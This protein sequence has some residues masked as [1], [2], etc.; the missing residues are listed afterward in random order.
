MSGAGLVVER[1]SHRFGPRLV[2]DAVSL[3]VAP[4][5]V[6]CL[7]GPSG[8]G[9]STLLRIVAGLES[10]QEGAISIGGTLVAGPDV[11]VPPERRGV[12]LMFQDFALFP[13]L[14]VIQN[15]MFGLTD[16]AQA[17]R[18][19]RAKTALTR[20]AMDAFADMYPHTLS[21]GEQQRV[22]LARALAPRPRVMLLDEPFSGLDTGTRDRVRREAIKLL[23]ETGTPTLLVTHDPEEAMR[24]ASHIVLMR[25][26][27]IEQDGSPRDLYH[28]PRTAFCA[29]F[30]GET[31]SVPGIVR[32]GIVETSV[33]K[34]SANGFAEGAAV[35]VL[36]RPE[37]IRLTATDGVG[38]E[39][40]GADATVV[41]LRELGPATLMELGVD[42]VERPVVARV[43]LT[44][45]LAEGS[46]VRVR[47]DRDRVFVFPRETS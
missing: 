43:A 29:K 44:E 5:E 26:G 27:R 38:Q 31:N 35:D 11:Q 2:L 25:E 33:G 18:R 47:L 22:A 36:V 8:S 19:E 14:S 7:L 9:K 13:H 6:V 10:L 46:R 39:N 40:E 41:D 42:G 23:R 20:V 21:G 37:A 30:L 15:V 4:G 28:H 12:G 24:T 3:T 16:L 1:V 32:G 34:V 17:E 45:P